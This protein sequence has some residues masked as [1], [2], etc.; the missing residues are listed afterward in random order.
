MKKD[1]RIKSI[2]KNE[3]NSSAIV[4]RNKLIDCADG[5]YSI[6]CDSDDEVNSNM[7]SF[8]TWLIQQE[9]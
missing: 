1:N 7:C 5:D 2:I 8:A 6:W 9:G 4:S 3:V